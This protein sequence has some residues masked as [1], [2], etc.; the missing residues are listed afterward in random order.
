MLSYIFVIVCYPLSG[1]EYVQ[2]FMFV[3]IFIVGEDPIIKGK[4]WDF[5]NMFNPATVVY[6]SPATTWGSNVIC[7]GNSLCS[8]ILRHILRAISTFNN[9]P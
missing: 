5:I 1:K 2:D 6:L 9:N 3:Y 4:A 8:I 7:G